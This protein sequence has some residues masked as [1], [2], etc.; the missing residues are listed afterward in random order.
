MCHPVQGLGTGRLVGEGSRQKGGEH[1]THLFNLLQILLWSLV[2]LSLFPISRQA[3]LILVYERYIKQNSS[4]L[5]G[6]MLLI[7]FQFIH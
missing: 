3:F 6:V 4:V 7:T 2:P 5:T 1:L